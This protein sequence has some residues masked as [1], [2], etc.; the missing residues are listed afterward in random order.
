MTL[1]QLESFLAVAR[2]RTFRGAAGVM[3]LSQPALS[4]Q[5]KELETELGAPVFDRLGR[6]VALTEA[7]RLLEG[8][9]TRVFSTLDDARASIAELT[10]LSRGSLLIGA[11]TT[12]GAYLLP[13][14]IARYRSRHPGVGV[15]LRIAN[16][17]EIEARVGRGEM[18]LGVVGGHV[19]AKN[20]TCVQARL[21]DELVLIVPPSHPFSKRKTIPPEFLRTERL[22]VREVGSATR[23]VTEQLFKKA[24]IEPAETMELEHTEAIKR[25]VMAGLG[26]S[27]VSV[28]AIRS[29]EES[30]SLVSV[31]LKG[32]PLL[33]HFHVIRRE[34]RHLSPAARAFV[35]LLESGGEAGPSRPKRRR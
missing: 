1:R 26:L 19:S 31:R 8:Y 33:R 9:A 35:E 30:G 22:I 18:D 10:G 13:A 15:T 2:A 25:A 12:P 20:E 23:H 5:I 21:R 17:R 3:A 11:S 14:L 34:S 4:Q 24:R 7:G 16:S 32:L 6:T 28:Y 29:E 27:M